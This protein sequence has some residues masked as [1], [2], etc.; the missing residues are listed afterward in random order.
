VEHLG[1]YGSLPSFFPSFFFLPLLPFLLLFLLLSSPHSIPPLSSQSL[2]LSLFFPLL[3]CL[4]NQME[5]G[6]I[7]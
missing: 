5:T 3:S 1:F 6:Y 2:S 4:F 7:V